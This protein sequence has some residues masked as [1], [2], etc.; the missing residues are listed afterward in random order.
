MSGRIAPPGL[1]HLQATLERWQAR[2]EGPETRGG[3]WQTGVDMVVNHATHAVL[4][5]N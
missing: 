4:V 3:G 2:R 5:H 1:S